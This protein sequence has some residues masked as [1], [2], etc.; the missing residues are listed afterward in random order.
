MLRTFAAFLI[1]PLWVPLLL[2]PYA[3]FVMLPYAGQQRGIV[4]IVGLIFSYGGV[5]LFG[6][7]AFLYLRSR[8]L[9]APWIAVALGF[10]VGPIVWLMFLFLFG[11]AL[12]LGVRLSLDT[13][14]SEWTLQKV[15]MLGVP[16]LLGAL[17]GITLWAIARP[18]RP[19][20]STDRDTSACARPQRVG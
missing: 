13:L 17:I 15:M 16:G 18:D 11:L 4:V 9:T 10:A 8:N 19:R 5:L 1:A 20:A 14:L 6:L 2:Y 3:L 7:P 12:G